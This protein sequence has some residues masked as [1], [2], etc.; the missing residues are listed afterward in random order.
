M[1]PAFALV[2]LS[3]GGAPA[4]AGEMQDAVAFIDDFGHRALKQLTE[5]NLPDAELYKRFRALFEDG[6]DVPFIAK[7]ALG[8]FWPRATDQEK[9]EYMA[10]FEDY[11]VQV[12]AQKFRQYAGQ[13]FQADG[14]RPG[15]EDMAT[16][17]STVVEPDGPATKIDWVVGDAG[18]KQKIRDIKIEGVSMITSYRDQFANEILQH[19][20]KVA[21]LIEALRQKTAHIGTT[22]NG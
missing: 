14:S 7:S 1:L 20:G 21:G 4:Q 6:F 22:D 12:Y 18:G 5:P 10:A 11:M 8:R 17:T 13:T 2:I 16:V 19:E 9:S 3:F 15:P